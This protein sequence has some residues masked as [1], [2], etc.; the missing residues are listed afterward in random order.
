MRGVPAPG[1]S[2]HVFRATVLGDGSPGPIEERLGRKLL[3]VVDPSS[4]EGQRLLRSGSVEI[5]G[6]GGE[7]FGRIR[8]QEAWRQLIRRLEERLESCDL[9]G[10]ELVREGLKRLRSRAARDKRRPARPVPDPSR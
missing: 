2:S 9:Q 3:R 5:L 1:E 6:P 4:A 7:N 10:E 8:M